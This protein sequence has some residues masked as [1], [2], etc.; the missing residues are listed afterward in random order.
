MVYSCI[1]RIEL[2]TKCFIG[3][4]RF[5]PGSHLWDYQE[6]PP[7]EE[8]TVYAEL[9]PGDVFMM[10][11]G[12]FHGGSANT[13][14]DEERVIL[15]TFN[16]RGWLR[17]EEN[18]YLANSMESIKGLPPALQERMGYGLSLPFMGWVDLQSPMLMLHPMESKH[19]KDLL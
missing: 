16:C 12:C 4:T 3:A 7:R 18:Q 2:A 6:G 9:N 15:S 10:L 14:K 5:I 11:S 19:R 17:Q 13:T 1:R 8:Q